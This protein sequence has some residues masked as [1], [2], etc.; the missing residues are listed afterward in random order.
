[1]P[2]LRQNLKLLFALKKVVLTDDIMCLLQYHAL[3]PWA[4]DNI[5]PRQY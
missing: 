2:G 5:V 1:M 4:S 3:K